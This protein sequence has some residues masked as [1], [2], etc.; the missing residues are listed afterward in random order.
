MKSM[1]CFLTHFYTEPQQPKYVLGWFGTSAEDFLNVYS[2]EEKYD[3]M[4]QLQYT[5]HVQ[6]SKNI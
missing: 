3:Q 6:K 5:L 2:T 1:L 4:V